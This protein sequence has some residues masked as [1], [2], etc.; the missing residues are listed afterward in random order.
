VQPS[1][2]SFDSNVNFKICK[3]SFKRLTTQI[4][5]EMSYRYGTIFREIIDSKPVE[6][7]GLIVGKESNLSCLLK[8]SKIQYLN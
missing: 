1:Y 2:V 4:Q 7:C 6:F 5:I 3:Y 8:Q